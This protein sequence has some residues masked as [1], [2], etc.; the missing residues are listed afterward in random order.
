MVVEELVPE[1]IPP[2]GVVALMADGRRIPLDVDY[3]G[4][5]EGQY[6]WATVW[7]LRERP[8]EVVTEL[9]PPRSTVRVSF[10][11]EL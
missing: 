7:R 5:E 4:M 6:V 3:V 10:R 9:L 11:G 8:V 1:P 2:R